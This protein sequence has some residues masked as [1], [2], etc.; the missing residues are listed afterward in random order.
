MAG[1]MEC[2][3][4]VV[5]LGPGGEDVAG[6]LAEAGLHTVGI[7]AELLG[8]ECPY[9][10]CIPSKMMV[11]AAD[12]L[13]EGRR[14]PGMAGASEVSPDWAPVAR[15]IR[16]EATDTW[17]DTVAVE[18]FEAKGGHFVRGRA[19]VTSPSSVE[20]RLH[21]DPDGVPLRITASKALV[22]ATGAGPIIPPIFDG[23]P[24]WTNRGA[25]AAE[26]LPASLAIV[27]GGAIGLEIG[28]AMSR[29]GVEVTV[30]EAADRLVAAEEPEASALITG[31]LER[32]G[33]TILTG[34]RIEA[35]ETH[36]ATGV[37]LHLGDG[38]SVSAEQLLVATGRRPDLA[39][40]GAGALG[41]PGFE[42]STAR[43][44]PVD[45][46]MAVMPGVWAVGD[47]T[48]QGAFTHVAMYQARICA[49]AI[50][51]DPVADADYTALPR[52]TFTDPEIGSVGLTEAAAR[53]GGGEVSVLHGSVTQSA[54][55][56][57]H[58]GEGFVKLV[59]RDGVVVGATSA[60]P[61]GGEVLSMLALAVHARLPLNTL[62]T[63]IFAYPT[64]HRAVD[65]ALWPS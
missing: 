11:R 4:V 16:E 54:R 35:A 27:G 26:T 40:L 24:Y 53:A 47:V 7:E 36:G 37:T 64:F 60:G 28:Q 44:I 1:P 55:G 30:V 21:G 38:R 22:L 32:E 34:V 43:G 3:A 52:V 17:D 33:M 46:Q 61:S 8:G 50:L 5:G 51:G 65:S 6:R 10:G 31:I 19:R 48:G 12:L 41:L 9:W 2:D 25:V 62:R 15:R 23:V 59:A 45:P 18:R 63:M 14:I 29:F 42:P 13:A 56:W 39:G 58:R 20:V 57:I 49:A